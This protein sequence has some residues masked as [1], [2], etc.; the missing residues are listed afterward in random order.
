MVDVGYTNG[1]CFLAPFRG[2]WYHLNDWRDGHQPTTPK[3]LVNMSHSY[4]SLR[5]NSYY[6]FDLKN[7]II[8]ACC[9][10][11]NYIRLEMTID[12]FENKFI[13]T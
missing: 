7:K 12:L 2:Q 9:L 10:L 13:I 5:D 6:P 3:E 8:M 4:A 11:H 1:E